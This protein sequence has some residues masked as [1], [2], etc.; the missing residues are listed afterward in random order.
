MAG[1]ERL[2]PGMSGDGIESLDEALGRW[3]VVM[4]ECPVALSRPP[5]DDVLVVE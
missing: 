4:P 1:A 2:A 3:E 5:V